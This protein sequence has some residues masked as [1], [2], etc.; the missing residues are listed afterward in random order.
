MHGEPAIICAV[1]KSADPE[2]LW[3]FGVMP[4]KTEDGIVQK[5]IQWMKM[6]RDHID[7]FIAGGDEPIYYV[8]RYRVFFVRYT[9]L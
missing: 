5:I 4:K 6:N 7:D 3:E 9:D 2:D 8:D 1:G